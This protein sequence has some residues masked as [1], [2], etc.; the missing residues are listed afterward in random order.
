MTFSEVSRE[1]I[2]F[3]LIKEEMAKST[4]EKSDRHTI[5]NLHSLI[6]FRL[7][8]DVKANFGSVIKWLEKRE[9]EKMK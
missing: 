3:H 6:S 5:N 8:V 4:Q 1:G 2:F 7:D 9:K